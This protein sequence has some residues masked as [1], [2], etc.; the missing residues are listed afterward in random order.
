MKKRYCMFLMLVLMLL[1]C[2]STG[3]LAD[4]EVFILENGSASVDVETYSERIAEMPSSLT[5]SG[6]NG[7]AISNASQLAAFR[8]RVNAGEN[9]LNAYLTCDIDLESV[10]WE[11]IG[12]VDHPYSGSFDG[13][14]YCILNLNAEGTVGGL[15]GYSDGAVISSVG[16]SGVVVG[17]SLAGGILGRGKDSYIQKCYN[18]C[19]VAG[20]TVSGGIVGMLSA[21]Y[22][23]S[24]S[25]PSAYNT[26]AIA[27][28]FNWG[29]IYCS[30]PGNTGFAGGIVGMMD[31]YVTT[32]FCYNWGIVTCSDGAAGGIAGIITADS[33]IASVYNLVAPD[34]ADNFGEIVG[35]AA[36][37]GAVE[38]SYFVNSGYEGISLDESSY[39]HEIYYVNDASVLQKP[40]FVDRLNNGKGDFIFDEFGINGGFPLLYWEMIPVTGIQL[41]RT[42]AEL[43]V[44]R[45]ITLNPTIFPDNA[46]V[47][48]VEW[49]TSDSSVATVS[50]G[51]VTALKAGTAT[52]TATT[53]DGGYSASCR[54]TVKS[55]APVFSDVPSGVWYYDAVYDLVGRGIIN[56]MSDTI[57][58]PQDNITRAQFAKILAAASGESLSA[59]G[60]QSV[61]GDVRSTDWFA[62]YVGWAYD[63]GIV[64]GVSDT[65]FSPNAKITRE[66]MAAMICR[67]ADY[68]KVTLSPI[69]AKLIFN[70][71]S[72]ISAWAKNN[73]YAMQQAGIINGYADGNGFIFKPQGNATRAEAAKMIS[74][75]LDL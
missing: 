47:W 25:E 62:P 70:D 75:F 31:G 15:F 3:V 50:D 2:C 30:F 67:Y 26:S 48:D 59:F 23:A 58:A 35:F 24:T 41:D 13:N 33:F 42:S 69:N 9:N 52:I 43:T 20:G 72:T 4:S 40:D 7:I 29:D 8:D 34:N 6:T 36:K 39:D 12:T 63:K 56:G 64:K 53:V 71:D 44:G 38:N 60:G 11:P 51:K 49:E 73:V 5:P 66:Q 46:A 37:N 1:V 68:K 57:F 61:F 18:F 45:S 74:S 22:D 14:G 65:E 32:Y 28:C 16:V 19:D 10:N 55:S 27:S 21:S 54:V 17:D